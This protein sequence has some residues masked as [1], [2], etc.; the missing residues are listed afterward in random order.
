MAADSREEKDLTLLASRGKTLSPGYFPAVSG[1]LNLFME[2]SNT[3]RSQHKMS[4]RRAQLGVSVVKWTHVDLPPSAEMNYGELNVLDDILTDAPDQDDELYNPDSEQDK[5]EKKGSKRKSDRMENTESKRQKTS[6]HSSRQMMPK[7]PSSS[8]SNNKRIVTTKGKPVSEYKNEEYQRSDRNRRPDGDRKTRVSS[9]SR[10]PY[11]G[12]PEKTCMRKRDIDRRA[13]SS[14]P[15][16][17]ERIRH[18]VDRRPSRSSHSSKEEVNSEEYCSDHETGSSGSSEQGNT[19]NEEEGMEEE[20]DDEGEED[21]EVEEDGEEDE[22]EYEQDERDQ[23]EGNDYDTRSEASDSD[24]ESASF[25]DGSVRSASGS[26]ASDEKKKERKRA[27]GISPIVFDRSG[28]SASESYAGSEKKHEKLS[29]SVRAVQKDQTSKLKYILQDARFFLIK[30]NN[31]ENVSLAKAKGVWSTLPV[32]EKKLNAAFRSA[33]SVILI[34][35]VRESGKFQDKIINDTTCTFRRELPFTKSAHLTNPWNEH[36]PV[37]IGR[38]GQEIEPE[39]G[40]QLCLLFP[41][42]ESIDLYQLIHKMRHKRRMHSQP[43]SRGRPS[44]RDPVRDV[45]RRRPEDYD[46]HNSRKKPRIDYPPEFHQRP[47]YIKDPRYPEVDRRFSGV[48]RDVFLNGPPYPGMEQPPHHPYY[49]HHAPPPQAHPPYSGHHPVPHEARY[50]DKRVH[51]YDMRVDDFLRRT[52]AVV[53]GRRSRPRER[54]R[55]RERDRPRDNRRDRERDRG[56]DRE[57]ERERIC[58]RDRDRGE[59]GRY[60]R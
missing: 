14:T 7:P 50:R 12:Q 34:F 33:R 25:T 29:S 53:S 57:R 31:H 20:E 45:G 58:D 10:D 23:K 17:S 11:K 54:D 22:E 3:S 52:Q 2:G 9:S 6:V 37:K 42:D 55:E 38:D 46:I 35:S 59:R 21:E 40:T 16:G 27:R 5:S 28:S 32:N 41:P 44:R 30:S 4:C 18:D 56:R 13:K 15:D 1:E 49:Q 48:R 43:R 26:E 24:S 36:K 19:E 47:G 60:R 51:D 8:V 39:C